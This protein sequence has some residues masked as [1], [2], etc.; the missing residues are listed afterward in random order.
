MPPKRRNEAEDKREARGEGKRPK[1]D[2]QSQEARANEGSRATHAAG[3]AR[4]DIVDV[5]EDAGKAVQCL[6][7]TV[8]T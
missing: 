1:T 8:I 4:S 5:G 6:F 2:T 7:E 3:A